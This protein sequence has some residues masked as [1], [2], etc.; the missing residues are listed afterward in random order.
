MIKLA[1]N[2]SS[3]YIIFVDGGAASPSELYAAS[4]LCAFIRQVSGAA[5]PV[6]TS[7][8]TLDP[9]YR[10]G[11]PGYIFVGKSVKT[12][13]LGLDAEI[14]SAGEEGF[15]IRSA[16]GSI[17]I[18]GG[19]KRGTLYGVYD[20]LETYL[21]CR[22]YTP[23]VSSI[24]ARGVVELPDIDVKKTPAFKIREAFDMGNFDGDWSARNKAN[25]HHHRLLAHHGGGV[26]YVGV[27]SFNRLVPPDKYFDA[28]PEYFSEINGARLKERS[29]LCLTNP[30]VLRI[31]IDSVK[32]TIAEY[33]ECTIISV[34][35]NDWANW[36]E[37]ENC[38]KIDEEEESHM[39]TVL[40]FVN[41]VH[42]AITKEHPH[43]SI[44][45]LAYQYTRNLP[46]ITRPR[47]GL[48]IRLCTIECCFA[49]P[50]EECHVDKTAM[51]SNFSE[52]IAAW[53]KVSKDI[54][55]W[56]YTTD[57]ANYLMP[58]A[59]LSVLK[60]NLEFFK[61]HGVIGLFEEG[62]PNTPLSYAGELRQYVL[63]KLM[64][65]LDLDDKLLMDEF[66]AGVFGP[67]APYVK[68]F[69]EFWQEKS[70]ASGEHL[71]ENDA[72]TRVYFTR[73]NLGAARALLDKAMIMAADGP[74]R[75]RIEKIALSCDFMDTMQMDKGPA[76]DAAVDALLAKC[77][78]MGM[79]RVTEW[80]TFEQSGEIFKNDGALLPVPRK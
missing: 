24:P 52:D 40:R 23:D 27:H 9:R 75:L 54:Y 73:E 59:N 49:H 26:R 77:K 18:A 46:K 78:R 8:R 31:A 70:L 39:G 4:E 21:G 42:D 63:A 48:L 6:E 69:Y 76:K 41:A 15:I 34:S 36:C 22:W 68:A 51:P 66:Y 37:C 32:K 74:V 10:E 28:H 38:R 3:N 61:K 45:T 55:L 13:E 16:G 14:D 12:A 30:D 57:F 58:F 65:D 2:G 62:A 64:Y 17:V 20:F 72:V 19:R 7:A 67:A 79:R 50:L 35:Q 29:Q 33:P 71:F 5:L 60:R 53:S 44:D 56:D 11:A 1:E 25:G 80:H 47:P 43:I